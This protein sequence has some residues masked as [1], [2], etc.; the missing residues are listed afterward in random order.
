M[1]KRDKR[2]H[3]LKGVAIIAVLI[4][5]MG[6]SH[7]LA[8]TAEWI[9][10]LRNWT[11]WCVLLFLVCAGVLHGRQWFERRFGFW[12]FTRR[13]SIR[14]LVPFVVLTMVYGSI[15]HWCGHGA[16]WLEAVLILPAYQLYF[17]PL[18]WF[19]GVAVHCL[20]C[21]G[22][23]LGVKI[24]GWTALF[25]AM[26]FFWGGP[27]SGPFIAVI[28][29]GAAAYCLGVVI[30]S[31]I[32]RLR[33]PSWPWLESLGEASGTIFLYHRPYLLGV[34]AIINA[35]IMKT[36]VTQLAGA[37]ICLTITAMLLTWL[38]LRL[39]DTRLRWILL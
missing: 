15:W 11:T 9:W 21:A 13:R 30:Q 3:F 14:L 38:H 34:L 1:K 32:F 28:P 23:L 7:N 8:Q 2:I 18:V 19:I 29:W 36:P 27:I 33:L 16:S 35:Q 4:Q 39:R 6:S 12:E 10:T 5:H 22:D 31:K 26:R 25:C 20:L 24:F 37:V 17:L